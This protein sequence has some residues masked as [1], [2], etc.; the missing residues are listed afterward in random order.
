MSSRKKKRIFK[1]EDRLRE[2]LDSIRQN[3][4]CITGRRKRRELE[5]E[6]DRRLI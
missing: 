3:N 1:S 2:L 4:I 5:R 6:R